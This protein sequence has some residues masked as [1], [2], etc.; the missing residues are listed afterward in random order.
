VT[1]AMRALREYNPDVVVEIDVTE[2][3]RCMVGLIIL[4]EGKFFWMNNGASGYNDYSTYRTKSMRMVINKYA[5]II[6]TELFTQAVYPHNPYPFFA[7]RYNVNTTL[8]GG[9]GFWG[10]LQLMNGEQRQRVGAMV[11]KSKKVLPYIANLQGEVEGVIGAAPEVYVQMNKEKAA[12][13]VI[14]FSGTAGSFPVQVNLNTGNCL[15]VLNHA[16]RLSSDSLYLPFQFNRPDDTREAFVLPNLGTGISITAATAWLDD[17]QLLPGQQQLIIKAGG[18]GTITIQ[19]PVGFSIQSSSSI[20]PVTK[21]IAD[22]LF[23][24]Y[25]VQMNNKEIINIKWNKTDKK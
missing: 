15:A 25:T 11:A 16:Y 13:Q 21:A 9:H 6:P 10:N 14:A 22:T 20:Q 7:Q 3:E 12:G 19:L 23:P 1:A 18:N 17:V 5:S 24:Y 8:I 2:K 4:Q